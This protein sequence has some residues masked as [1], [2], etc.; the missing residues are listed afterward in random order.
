MER[1][2][3]LRA[4]LDA[5]YGHFYGLE[6][7]NLTSILDTTPIVKRQDELEYGEYRTKRLLFENYDE[8][9]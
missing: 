4:D 7:E 8:D 6:R 9:E 5:R 1:P 2:A 3:Q